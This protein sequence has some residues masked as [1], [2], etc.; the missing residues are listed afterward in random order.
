MNSKK[1]LKILVIEDDIFWFDTLKLEIDKRKLSLHLRWSPNGG[2]AMALLEGHVAFDAIVMNITSVR[3]S[4]H[5]AK[6]IRAMGIKV[7][8]IAWASKDHG[9]FKKVS[10]ELGIDQ[11]LIKQAETLVQDLIAV[12]HKCGVHQD[13][14]VK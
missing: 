6:K 12:L 11:Y 2:K 14:E 3:D 5:T 13:L 10:K 4:E 9:N 8:I 1:L 7:P